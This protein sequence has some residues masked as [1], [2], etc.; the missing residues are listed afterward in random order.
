MAIILQ[1]PNTLLSFPV[2]PKASHKA[3][4]LLMSLLWIPKGE[5]RWAQPK[6]KAESEAGRGSWML[7]SCWKE[8]ARQPNSQRPPGSADSFACWRCLFE[9][10]EIERR[11]L[12]LSCFFSPASCEASHNVSAKA[13][14]EEVRWTGKVVGGEQ[15]AKHKA[16]PTWEAG[17]SGA[18]GNERAA[19]AKQPA[20]TWLRIELC[21]LAVPVG[22]LGLLDTAT[23]IGQIGRLSLLVDCSTPPPASHKASPESC[24]GGEID[25]RSDRGNWIQGSCRAAEANSPTTLLSI[26]LC[27]LAVPVGKLAPFAQSSSVASP[28]AAQR[29]APG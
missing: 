6:R 3:L 10:L 12:L 1:C 7:R 9:S 5:Q 4:P 19:A 15:L 22:E 18:A 27:L 11:S 8:R 28:H 20:A 2:S 24:A 25:G 21:L 26:E 14:P 16:R 29:C 17:S 23:A 13:S